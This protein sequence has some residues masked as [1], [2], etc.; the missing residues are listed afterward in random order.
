MT[1]ATYIAM[2]AHLAV[3]SEKET[4]LVAHDLFL[5]NTFA[6]FYPLIFLRDYS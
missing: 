1:F 2:L 6:A 5:I 3:V 4:G